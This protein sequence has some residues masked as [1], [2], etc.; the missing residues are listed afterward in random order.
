MCQ[1]SAVQSADSRLFIHG[2]LLLS[3]FPLLVSSDSLLL[4]RLYVSRTLPFSPRLNNLLA[5]SYLQQYRSIP[6]YIN[7]ISSNVSSFIY[8][9]ISFN[10]LFSQPSFLVSFAYLSKI[11]NSV[12]LMVSVA[13][14]FFISFTY[15]YFLLSA[16]SGLCSSSSYLRCNI[17]LFI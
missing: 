14:L 17:K 3:S 12:S 2:R 11:P 16:N 9:F 8:N 15:Y 5:L 13:L 7:G 6:L 4:S 1:N 10:P